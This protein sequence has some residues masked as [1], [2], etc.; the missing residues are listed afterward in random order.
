MTA[1]VIVSQPVSTKILKLRIYRLAT[2]RK[3]SDCSHGSQSGDPFRK[4]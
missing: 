2:P 3:I 1:N 4:S